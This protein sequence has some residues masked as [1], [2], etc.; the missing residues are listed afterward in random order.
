ME[1]SAAT[2]ASVLA[3]FLRRRRLDLGCF[4]ILR[5]RA[6]GIVSTMYYGLQ[7]RWLTPKQDEIACGDHY[8]NRKSN[9]DIVRGR[10]D[11]LRRR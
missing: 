5:V 3:S 10:K 8:A 9:R 4:G 6:S 7:I 1:Q 11:I 2:T